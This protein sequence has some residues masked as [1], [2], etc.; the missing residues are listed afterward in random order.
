MTI[1][2]SLIFLFIGYYLG[3]QRYTKDIKKVKKIMGKSKAIITKVKSVGTP[4]GIIYRP[5]ASR[6]R[7][8]SGNPTD[9]AFSETLE[10]L[11]EIQEARKWL[12]KQ[13]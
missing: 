2:A 1:I 4:S 8:L 3:L 6:I 13:K 12:N 5:N 11:P 10:K 9:E 7:K